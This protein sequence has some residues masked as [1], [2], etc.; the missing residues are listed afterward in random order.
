MLRRTS[1]NN[2]EK[3]TN[4]PFPLFVFSLS[5]AYLFVAYFTYCFV[6][7]QTPGRMARASAALFNDFPLW[8]WIVSLPLPIPSTPQSLAI[9]LVVLTTT[10]FAVYGLVIYLIWEFP[11]RPSSLALVILPASA[12]FI[13]STFALPNMNTDVFNYMLRGR[14]GAIHNENPYAV[15]A[16]EISHDPVY[17]YASHSYTV[18]PTGK[19]PVWLSVEIGLGKLTGDDVTRNLFIYRSAFLLINLANLGLITIL[20]NKIRPRYILAGI[21]LYAWNPI[22][23]LLGTGKGD[24]VIVFFLLL[25]VLFLVFERR[26]IAIIPLTLSV[27]IKLTTF[28]FVAAYMIMNFKLKRWRDFVVH[29]IL[30]VLT[31]AVVYAPYLQG[32]DTVGRPVNVVNMAGGSMPSI[33][34]IILRAGFILLI[35]F[36]GLKQNGYI[37]HLIVGWT[38]LALFFS[39]FLTRFQMAWY[40]MTLIALVSLFPDWRTALITVVLSFSGFLLNI[41]NSGF[42]AGFPAPH[43]GI[44]R[45]V[46]YL[47]LPTAVLV[48]MAAI[49][50]WQKFHQRKSEEIEIYPTL[51]SG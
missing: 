25:A 21:V 29:P 28:P 49:L 1:I 30:F 9:L 19:Y 31:A 16:D 34:P 4:S 18:D 26:D 35:L 51:S 32:A 45:Y 50:L 48:G 24:T 33:L 15:A 5:A 39:L 46:V 3:K 41:W 42:N 6:I 7:P 40:L 10:T 22:V 17:P 13:L 20:L 36:V 23:V 44:P 37:R 11:A 38:F 12:Y 14:L 43:L 47:A 2:V 27:L 8:A